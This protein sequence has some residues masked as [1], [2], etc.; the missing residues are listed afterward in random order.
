MTISKNGDLE[1]QEFLAFRLTN[2]QRP[3]FGLD[4]VREEWE[5]VEIKSGTTV[6]FDQ[7]DVIRKVIKFDPFYRF[8]Y[9]EFDTVMATRNRTTILP[10]TE[11]GKEKKITPTHIIAPTPS[12]CSVSFCLTSGKQ[13][14]SIHAFN[15]RNHIS[16]PIDS[17][18]NLHTLDELR[19]WITNY[20]ETC[21]PDYFNK[22]NRM[23]TMPHRTI[24]YKPGDIFRFE[25][26]RVHYGFALIIGEKNKM[27]P[28]LPAEHSW[29]SLLTV[30]LLFRFYELKTTVKD[31]SIEEI[32]SYPLLRA[33]FMSDGDIIWGRHDIVG[34][35]QL[36]DNDIDF[37]MHL[38]FLRENHGPYVL[39][40]SWGF[41]T[42]IADKPLDEEEVKTILEDMPESDFSNCGVAL[43]PPM[44]E[45]L[46]VLDSE[47]QFGEWSDLLHPNNFRKRQKVYEWFGF[48]LNLDLDSFN[49]QHNGYT[50]RQYVDWVASNYK[51]L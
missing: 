23:R 25:I 36:E 30:P 18:D 38:S 21:P 32:C 7:E 47:P 6:Y 3:Y 40:F 34:H 43:S 2:E 35:K 13:G 11:K 27:S 12:G 19:H 20:I 22:V 37:P 41:G 9:T 44:H 28:L 45:L 26:D 29:N 10:K 24:K 17:E 4:P 42:A 49:L 50:R 33:E 1:M 39:R 8:H 5:E 16:L 14:S 31:L 48:P 46:Q 51:L 15:P